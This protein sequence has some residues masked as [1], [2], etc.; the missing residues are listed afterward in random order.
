[1]AFNI[2]EFFKGL[3][4]SEENT[5]SPK[6][7]QITPGG[8]ANTKTTLTSSQTTNKTVTFPDDTTTLLGT[9]TTQSVS[10]KTITNSTID[11]T[12]IG[13]TTP[14]AVTTTSL[15]A[16]TADINAGT[17]DNTVIGG[18][19][20]AAGTFTTLTADSATIGG[21]TIVDED[22]AQTLKNKSLEDT[23]TAIT[24]SI[25][26]TKKIMFDAAGTTATKI[27][28]ASSQTV[29]RVL[30]LPDATDT[31]V[32]R[33]TVDTLT[34]KTLTTPAI[35]NPDLD[36]GTIDGTTIG[37]ATPASAVFTS[38]ESALVDIFGGTIEDTT[39]GI[40]T[41]AAAQFTTLDTTSDLNVGGNTVITGD[42]TV[43]G[44]TTTINTQNLDVEDKNIT[45]NKNGNDVSSEGAGLT[46]DRTG[47]E[48][49]LIYKDASATKWAAG[50][51][52]SEV[53][54]VGTTSTQTL[55]NKTLTAPAISGGT[56]DNTVI[57]GTTPADGTFTSVTA[58]SATVGGAAVTTATNSQTL[59]N[60]NLSDSTT[61]IVDNSDS[62]KRIAF[63]AAGSTGATTTITSSSLLN[64]TITLP[65]STTTLVGTDT[66]NTLTNKTLAYLQQSSA[67]DGTATGSTATITLPTTG[68]VRL[69]N[70]SLVSVAGI[71]AGA[72]GQNLILENKT[73]ATISILN[74][75]TGATAANRIQ[76]GTATTATMAA[77]ASF[78]FVYDTTSSRW[79]LVGGTGSGTG[80]GS[81]GVNYITNGDAEST[82]PFALY[83]YG[84]TTKPV[85]P[86]I[87]GAGGITSTISSSSP[88]AGSNSFLLNKTV[89]STV[90]GASFDIP[91]TVS[92][93][94]RAK[95][96]TI[97]F[98]YMLVSGT[99]Q[100]GTSTQDSELIIYIYDID[101]NV[102][103]EPSNYKFLS[104]STTISSKFSAQFQTS[105]NSTNYRL[106]FYNGTTNATQYSMKIDNIK[107]G[108]SQY[109]YGTPVTDG[110]LYTPTFGGITVSNS[111]IYARRLGDSLL[112]S[113]HY[114]IATTAAAIMTIT[115]P[116]G[117]AIDTTKMNS[118]V[119]NKGFG[120]LLRKLSA[121]SS[122]TTGSTADVEWKAYYNGSA[123]LVQIARQTSSQVYLS[124]N[125]S[126]FAS[127]SDR[128]DI[129]LLTIPISG[130][131]SS[132]QM[133]DNADTRIVAA[134]A[135]GDPASATSGNPI[136]VPTSSYDT[137]S[138]YSTSTGRYTVPVAGIYKVYGALQSASTATTLT[139]Y[140][141]AV[142]G[143]LAGNLDSNGEATFVGSISCVAGDLIDLRPG[144][145]VDAT[146]MA[147][148]FERL[149]GPS[150]IAATETVACRYTGTTGTTV[151]TAATAV[152]F[153]NRDYD[154][155]GIYNSTTGVA[156]IP[157]AGKYR[158][159]AEWLFLLSSTVGSGVHCSIYK[160]GSQFV[161]L[162]S[163]NAWVASTS[164]QVA[165]QGWTTL[166]LV[167]G[168][169]IEIRAFRDTNT[170]ANAIDTNT[171]LNYLNIERIGL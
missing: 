72:S 145:T 141:N 102:M 11:S 133:S 74:E 106:M 144:G 83:T 146:S 88:L 91:F 79:Q 121:T 94:Y 63:D 13:Q 21:S 44:T 160:N 9:A 122:L 22:S 70:G 95:A 52:G 58:T 171:L 43:N 130:W 29:D 45:V 55:T 61:F 81:G 5:N 116:P 75:D 71:G 24:D 93:A 168:D 20:P 131:S 23:T 123:N 115:L 27:T 136:I 4:I 39:I 38:M 6:Q 135:T 132:V 53:D 57:G 46:V 85:V 73:G 69:T 87:A 41:P 32:A 113:G 163:E 37:S 89:S 155:H 7:I 3:L 56:I 48:G 154:T 112:I 2:R 17:I 51:L 138:A 47:T 148:T 117:L 82:N 98:D 90:Q 164:V 50:S 16:T 100:V 101:N 119:G 161:R 152:V 8:T 159:G 150:A 10:N 137:H 62:T 162:K 30:T 111:D 54:L 120:R 36:G 34:N 19:T 18:T 65:S 64:S 156:T 128:V 104:N 33:N 143:P 67:N 126:T 76:T 167:A 147:I 103:I 105:S 170:T 110:V 14:A 118:V 28:I 78:S 77:N 142:A 166:N 15:V 108:P 153:N 26:P 59:T 134:S 158:I 109:V 127:A 68:I 107:V 60:K 124:E 114:T 84:S 165:V 97:E 140:K 1:M 149:S 139:I 66:T 169:T 157:A 12:P 99:F 92:P 80:S 49:S 86:G 25:D 31:L 96:N 40:S 151:G 42:L 129:E 125:A 35:T